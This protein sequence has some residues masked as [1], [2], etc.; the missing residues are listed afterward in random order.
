MN[1]CQDKF[2][3]ARQQLDSSKAEG[4][5]IKKRL[6]VA[7]NEF[8][9]I[10]QQTHYLDLDEAKDVIKRMNASL[11]NHTIDLRVVQAKVKA[12]ETNL[13]REYGLKGENTPMTQYSRR[14]IIEHLEDLRSDLM[15]ELSEASARVDA[16]Q[17]IRTGAE[18]YV[19][20]YSK[21]R[22][23]KS[24]WNSIKNSVSE[25]IKNWT[26]NLGGYAADIQAL[27]KDND[28]YLRQFSN[29]Q[30]GSEE[31]SAG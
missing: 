25:Q 2:E 3:Q 28:I 7:E 10:K 23:V 27:V 21:M 1:E 8:D 22:S 29:P 15:I 19:A 12:V 24:E 20:Q 26:K 14:E 13:E 9:R 16:A 18:D 11:E 4:L 6:T 31:Q 30:S 5:E 17:E